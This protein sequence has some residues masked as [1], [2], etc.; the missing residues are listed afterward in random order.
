MEDKKNEIA[1]SS[2]DLVNEHAQLEEQIYEISQS[3]SSLTE[4]AHRLEERN[5]ESE[6][7]ISEKNLLLEQAKID[8]EAHSSHLSSLQL[9]CA[10]LD[11]QLTFTSENEKR[12][13]GEIRKLKEEEAA[14]EKGKKDSRSAI[15]EKE[16]KIKEIQE[17]IQTSSEDNSQLK[18]AIKKIS[19]EKEAVSRQQKNLFQKRE[20]ISTRLSDLDKDLFR[21][22]AQAEKLE[23]HLESLA[24]YMWSE[25]EMTL[26]QARELKKEEFS[27]LPEIRRQ[28][29]DLKGKIKALGNINV[30]AIEDY[31][32]VSER[33]EFMRTQH[34]DLVNAQAELE[35]IIEELDTGM[36]RQFDEKFREIRAEFDKVFKELFGGGRGTLELLEGEDI[37]EAGIQIIA[38]PPGKKLQNMMQLSGGEKALTAISLLFAIQNLKPSPFCLLDEIEAALDDSNVDRFAGYLHKLTTNT[39]F[40][41]ITHRRGTMMSADRLYGIT[42]QEKGVSTLVSV[43]LIEDSLT[44]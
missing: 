8:R 31:K 20:E 24:S 23:E 18:E 3:R 16:A 25:Y 22:Q 44:K 34:E 26:S 1:E 43:N 39:Q 36:R 35:K 6:T 15:E 13:N 37:L 17:Q 9:E 32:E 27:S 29:E 11:Q 21:V 19:E 2:T 38:Q 7:L 40:I 33:Y 12:V 4:E 28:I 5:K 30:N 41:V 14:L 10:S 42:M